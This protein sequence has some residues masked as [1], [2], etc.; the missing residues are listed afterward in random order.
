MMRTSDKNFL[1]RRD[2]LK[3]L[4]KN[5]ITQAVGERDSRR[6]FPSATNKYDLYK[7]QGGVCAICHQTI[8][9]ERIED[10]NYLHIDH[11][12]PH[13]KGGP[14]EFDNAQLTHAACN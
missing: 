7:R 5:A 3:E 11:K 14:T 1:R 6:E 4:M 13:S 12:I 9:S 8:D 2:E 10:T